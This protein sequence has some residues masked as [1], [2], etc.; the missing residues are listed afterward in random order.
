[1]EQLEDWAFADKFTVEKT[2]TKPATTLKRVLKEVGVTTI[3][4]FKSD[5]QGLDLRLF[6]SLPNEIRSG[7]TVAEFEP[8]FIDAYKG[9]D[10]IHDLL[11]YM[12]SQPFWLADIVIKGPRRIS[13]AS[14]RSVTSSPFMRKLVELSMKPSPGWA[15]LTYLRII[16][17]KLT[18]RQLLFSW[19]AAR[20]LGQHGWAYEVATRGRTLYDD[21]IFPRMQRSS[22][23]ALFRSL[24]SGRMGNAAVEK[25]SKL[26]K[27]A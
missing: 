9:E 16:K 5:S 8:G 19:V 12:E 20:I 7:L 18:V 15:E 26:L 6:A 11:G 22:R 2:A 21:P 23:I 17:E 1:M 24:L 13:S 4:W 25:L 14:L 3:D 27:I 10:K